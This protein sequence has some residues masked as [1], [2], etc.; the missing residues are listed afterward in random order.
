MYE[1]DGRGN[2]LVEFAY[3]DA[4]EYHEDYSDDSCDHTS[5]DATAICSS[6]T[7]IIM[8]V[9]SASGEETRD[10]RHVGSGE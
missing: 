2:T 8:V 3:V 5:S 1:R 9:G 10:W 7:V 4:N 6:A